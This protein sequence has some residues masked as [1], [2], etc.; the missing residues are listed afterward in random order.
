MGNVQVWLEAATSSGSEVFN[1]GR[2]FLFRG[3]PNR[4]R[5]N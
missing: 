2:P 3:A 5:R 1:Y 4:P